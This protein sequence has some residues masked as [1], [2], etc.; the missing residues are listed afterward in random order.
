MKKQQFFIVLV[1]ILYH[2]F[3]LMNLQF[4]VWPEMLSYPYFL[5]KGFKLYSDFIVPYPPL[6]IFALS[7]GYSLLGVGPLFLK[8][9][10]WLMLSINDVII[11]LIVLKLTKMTWKAALAL[12][13][14]VSI[15]PLFEGNM[16]WFDIAIVTPLLLGLFFLVV[17]KNYFLSGFCFAIA[18]LT[19]QTT[20][21]FLLVA[22]VYLVSKKNVVKTALR[23]LVAPIVLFLLFFVYLIIKGNFGDFLNWNL[24]YPF[25]YWSRF[26]GYVQMKMGEFEIKSLL[27]LFSPFVFMKLKRVGWER[28]ETALLIFMLLIAGVVVYPRFS[29]FH[30]QMGIAI[31]SIFYGLLLNRKVGAVYLIVMLMMLGYINRYNIV[32]QWNTED[33]FYSTKDLEKAMVI[34]RKVQVNERVYLLGVQS[35]FYSMSERISP[36]PWFDNFGW[37]LE[38]PGVQDEILNKWENDLP[39]IIFWQ[40]PEAGNWFDLGVYQPVKIAS[41]I[42]DNY[43]KEALVWEGVWLWRRK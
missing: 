27:I 16:M 37:Y 6:L 17:K 2:L 18:C 20:V 14:Y 33:R 31:L 38:I 36:K 12:L 40:E 15:Q 35:G 13:I 24:F 28:G 39:E 26:P 19:K 25:V 41:W 5:N 1:L 9:L 22:F 21:L 43:N 8:C 32:R 42:Q 3:L 10:T 11:F 30:F 23:F 34:S 29:F 4:T 7:A